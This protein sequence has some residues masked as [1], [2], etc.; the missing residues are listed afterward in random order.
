METFWCRKTFPSWVH[1]A[2]Y[3][4]SSFSATKTKFIHTEIN[5]DKPTKPHWTSTSQRNQNSQDYRD[6]NALWFRQEEN[7]NKHQTLHHIWIISCF[8]FKQTKRHKQNE[9]LFYFVSTLKTFSSVCFLCSPQESRFIAVPP[10]VT[11][12]SFEILHFPA[13]PC[14]SAHKDTPPS[15]AWDGRTLWGD[16]DNKKSGGRGLTKS[17]TTRCRCFSVIKNSAPV[18]VGEKAIYVFLHL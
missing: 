10:S 18:G 6:Q 1:L 15:I 8:L 13:C 9:T 14:S 17:A 7:N 4:S 16:E 5:G 3:Y 11:V 2:L 12:P